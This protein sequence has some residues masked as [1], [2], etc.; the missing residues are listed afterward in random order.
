MNRLELP[1]VFINP[2]QSV[3]DVVSLNYNV[4]E[5]HSKTKITLHH[6]VVSL[7]LEG[8]KELAYNNTTQIVDANHFVLV[9]NGNCLMSE[10]LSKEH[11]FR[12]VLLFFNDQFLHRFEMK[13]PQY[14]DGQIPDKSVMVLK[15]DEF[16]KS[17]STSMSLLN[18]TNGMI[19]PDFIEHKL[20]ELLL[21]LAQKYGPK[22]LSI[23]KSSTSKKLDA[24]RRLRTIVEKHVYARMSLEELAFLCHMS[25]STFKREFQRIFNT[26][27]SRWIQEKRL[28][29]SRELLAREKE[30][31]SD[32]Y[33]K[34]GYESLSSFT[35]SFKQKYGI[36]PKQFQLE[37]N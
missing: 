28:E 34:V 29:R 26:S 33:H 18:D 32:I 20:E 11:Q 6:N 35:Q 3:P 23:Y 4:Q 19:G 7:I 12:S 13:Y 9:K 2:D 16:V 8:K 1:H 24:E 36:T 21:Y 17:F 14:F 15:T 10:H 5:A 25:L 22:V 31:P 37:K 30:R 27:P